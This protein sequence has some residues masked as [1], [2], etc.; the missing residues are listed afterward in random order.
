MT[1]A[2]DYLQSTMDELRDQ[3]E[4]LTALLRDSLDRTRHELQDTWQ[5]LESRWQ[6]LGGADTALREKA[7]QAGHELKERAR[8]LADELRSGYQELQS[9]LRHQSTA[10]AGTQ[11][12][13]AGGSGTPKEVRSAMIAEAAYYRASSRGFAGGDPLEDWL[14]AERE[15]DQRLNAQ[16]QAQAQRSEAA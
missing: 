15:I 2:Q 10:D 12:A 3:R 11:D 5:R 1:K 13:P 7:D 16:N 9:R 4:R 8:Q 14:S 6:E